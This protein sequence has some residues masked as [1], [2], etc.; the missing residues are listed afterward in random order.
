MSA[1]GGELH[2]GLQHRIFQ[3]A[4]GIYGLALNDRPSCRR[5]CYCRGGRRVALRPLA[6]KAIGLPKRLGTD[7][8]RR[9][10]S[11]LALAKE[12]ND[13]DLATTGKPFPVPV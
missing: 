12:K 1:K 8:A 4:L 5:A 10:N 13:T 2:H 6:R 3:K 7:A 11:G 9:K